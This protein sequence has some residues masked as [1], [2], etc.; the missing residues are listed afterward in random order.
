MRSDFPTVIGP[1]EQCLPLSRAT[2]L[3]TGLA[4]ASDLRHVAANGLPL[5]PLPAFAAPCSSGNTT[6]TTRAVLANR[7]ATTRAVGTHHAI[8]LLRVLPSQ[9]LELWSDIG[10]QQGSIP[11]WIGGHGTEPYE[12]KTQQLPG[13]GFSLSPQ[14]LSEV[15][16]AIGIA[17]ARIVFDN[18]QYEPARP[19]TTAQIPFFIGNKKFRLIR[20]FSCCGMFAPKQPFLLRLA[21]VSHRDLFNGFDLRGS[22]S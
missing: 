6:A 20:L 7:P 13:N 11:S 15:R 8:R 16:Y 4:V 18:G 2:G 12:Q 5:H 19:L 14:R 9:S 22:R 10:V 1:V 21:R 3:I 17:P